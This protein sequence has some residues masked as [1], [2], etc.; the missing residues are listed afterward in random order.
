SRALKRVEGGRLVHEGEERNLR[1]RVVESRAR[2]GA[3]RK[4][5]HGRRTPDTAADRAITLCHWVPPPPAHGPRPPHSPLGSAS[6]PP[7]AP[8]AEPRRHRT[9][10][11]RTT[12]HRRSSDASWGAG[13]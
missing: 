3:Q 5:G 9:G 2:T 13:H 4:R 10:P 12:D 8:R 7:R 11:P 6:P 1:Q